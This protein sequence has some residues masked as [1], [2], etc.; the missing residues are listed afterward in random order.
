M[1]DGTITK[2]EVADEMRRVA[3]DVRG[4]V[5]ERAGHWLPEEQPEKTAEI[6]ATFFASSM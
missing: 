6:L 4:E 3:T 1:T 2:D 5:I